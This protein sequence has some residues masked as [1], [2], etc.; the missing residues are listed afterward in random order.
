MATSMGSMSEL[1][2]FSPSEISS[3]CD[4]M[5]MT[6][7]KYQDGRWQALCCSEYLLDLSTHWIDSCCPDF[8]GVMQVLFHCISLVLI[9]SVLIK[10]V[11]IKSFEM[12]WPFMVWI[13]FISICCSKVTK[14]CQ[15]CPRLLVLQRVAQNAKSCSKVAEHNLFMPRSNCWVLFP[16]DPQCFQMQSRGKHWGRG[17]RSSATSD[18]FSSENVPCAY[19]N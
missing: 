1:L 18:D 12:K 11:L 6:L 2:P 16:R 15:S 17:S 14:E 8:V 4:A 7:S 9:K 19:N 5:I 3:D 13:G 10:P